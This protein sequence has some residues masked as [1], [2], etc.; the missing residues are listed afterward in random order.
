MKSVKNPDIDKFKLANDPM[1]RNQSL[2]DYGT[3]VPQQT[4]ITLV[5]DPTTIAMSKPS[6]MKIHAPKRKMRGNR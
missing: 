6:K 3:G 4:M 2:P 1:S 5:M